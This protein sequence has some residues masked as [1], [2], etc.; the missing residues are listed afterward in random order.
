[1]NAPIRGIAGVLL[2]FV[3]VAA[4]GPAL[5]RA[6]EHRA[7]HLDDGSVVTYDGATG[8][9]CW[10]YAVTGSHLAHTDCKTQEE[11]AKNGLFITTQ[12]K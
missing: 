6:P 1:M 10:S 7:I 12:H 2:G 9:Y 8:K 4:A 11:W 3:L 5:A